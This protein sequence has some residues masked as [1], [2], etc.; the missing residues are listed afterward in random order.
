MNQLRQPQTRMPICAA[1]GTRDAARRGA[2]PMISAAPLQ[3]K[4][5]MKKRRSPGRLVRLL[6]T[7]VWQV[8]V[9]LFVALLGMTVII[10]GKYSPPTLERLK[11]I[12]PKLPEFVG[13][14]INELGMAIVIAAILALTFE[15]LRTREFEAVAQK[16]RERVRRD[17]FN[18]TFGHHLPAKVRR[19]VINQVFQSPFARRQMVLHYFFAP[20][21][22]ASA[23]RFVR[24]RVKLSYVLHNTTYETRPF[25]F[26]ITADRPPPGFDM[27]HEIKFIH[28]SV[29]GACRDFT[30]D[31]AY[32]SKRPALLKSSP[33]LLRFDLDSAGRK[34]EVAAG[35]SATVTV[36]YQFVGPYE[37]G[38]TEID[39]GNHVCEL[40]FAVHL[41]D[42]LRDLYDIE[43][44][45]TKPE[46]K[47]S[48]LHDPAE[49][50]YC[51][52][53]GDRA[54]LPGQGIDLYWRMSTE[55]ERQRRLVE[56]ATQRQLNDLNP[57]QRVL[58]KLNV[59]APPQVEISRPPAAVP[60]SPEQDSPDGSE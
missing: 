38:H 8:A 14:G 47:E 16:E 6:R 10:T 33:G 12:D 4:V 60:G 17:V 42:E 46:L 35:K 40:E 20:I 59:Y 48:R 11:S 50:F 24:I 23:S 41:S 7:V 39:F 32:F 28:L 45:T 44:A 36:E 51:W 27:P 34:I 26:Y 52:N 56:E 54:L 21:V 9:W 15:A 58:H 43:A 37:A 3:A 57:F 31:E 18:T 1:T 53:L 5:S 30:L 22:E 29:E 13:D 25:A 55:D 49:G 2:C 19:E